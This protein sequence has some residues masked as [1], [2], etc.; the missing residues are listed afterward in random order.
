MIH[1]TKAQ[2]LCFQPVPKAETGD[3]IQGWEPIEEVHKTLHTAYFSHLH[4]SCPFH[5]LHHN[6]TIA[7]LFRVKHKSLSQFEVWSK[8]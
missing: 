6:Y 4:P 2:E 7:P 5:K 1:S 3:T 8:K